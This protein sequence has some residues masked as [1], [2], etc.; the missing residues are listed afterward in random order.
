M[1]DKNKN[2]DEEQKDNV[3]KELS[4]YDRSL[5]GL[6]LLP[7]GLKPSFLYYADYQII[8][9]AESNTTIFKFIWD[10]YSSQFNEQMAYVRASYST[11]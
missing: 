7:F 3:N 11:N 6:P 8:I 9:M 1:R 4:I 2:I 10:G 5:D